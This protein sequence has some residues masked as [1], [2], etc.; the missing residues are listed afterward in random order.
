MITESRLFVLTP[1]QVCGTSGKNSEETTIHATATYLLTL[2]VAYCSIVYELLLA[3]TLSA[4]MGNTVMRYSVTIGVYLASLGLGAIL[5]GD[6]ARDA[7]R[8]LGRI[9]ILLS[10][11]G[12]FA[13]LA[14]NLLA[15]LH[16]WAGSAA[17]A[18]WAGDS[19][20][21]L[22]VGFFVASHLIIV[23]IGVLSGYEVPLLIALRQ[24]DGLRTQGKAP[25]GAVN[26]VLGVDYFGSLL[27]AV[28][29]PLVL[30]PRLGVFAIASLTG[31]LN[32]AACLLLLA[33]KPFPDRRWQAVVA[34]VL[35]ISLGVS[36][37]GVERIEQ[38]CL[39]SFYH[40]Q[41]L[42]D[43]DSA[44]SSLDA[45]K[46][47]RVFRSP[48]QRIHLVQRRSNPLY[49][50]ILGV[51]SAKLRA[52]PEF[53]RH[54]WLYMVRQFQ[55]NSDYEEIYHEYFAHV[56]VQ[57]ATPPRRVLLL[58]AGDGLLARELLKYHQVR[59]LTLVDLDPVI[60]D[61]ARE[62][63]LLR[64]MNHSALHDPR[65]KVVAA[66][67]FAWLKT[68][69]ERYDAIYCDFPRPTNF[70]LSRLF[71]RD[72]YI[73]VRDH[74][75]PGGFAAA[76]LPGEGNQGAYM[77]VFKAAGFGTVQPFSARLEPDNPT[78]S[79]VEEEF[80][81]MGGLVQPPDRKALRA[82]FHATLV[83]DALAS[84]RQRFVFLQVAPGTP[85]KTFA[86]HNV[87]LYVLNARRLALSLDQA[88]RATNRVNTVNRPTLPP[89]RMDSLFSLKKAG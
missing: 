12:G 50:S 55:F 33:T 20:T 1:R 31:L 71:S 60:L 44:L 82:F 80:S 76:D 8:R 83:P 77:A 64:R 89:I 61:L 37:F 88:A 75:A 21:A 41:C 25:A 38:F 59:R 43:L 74:L 51:Y 13:V 15:A 72:F 49:D 36:L 9:E 18:F 2:I 4:I 19:H 45:Q 67:A 34:G 27:G 24:G 73:M 22:D 68:S 29:F 28:L 66:D 52:E 47:V 63:P 32:V 23:A 58:G 81:T 70:D 78:L 65:V 62:L 3:Q 84:V 79:Q 85:R 6:S 87:P 7:S 57:L 69:R 17:A 30:L 56:P 35:G 40:P 39:K 53:P 16:H 86:D 26:V 11:I 14:M 46:D 48:Y 42:T 5:C 10:L 54:T